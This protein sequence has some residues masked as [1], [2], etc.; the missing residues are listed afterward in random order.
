L[1]KI[2]KKADQRAIKLIEIGP[3]MEL[4]LVKIQSGLCDGE[5]LFHEFNKKTP[6]EI[7]KTERKRQQ[8]KQETA[9]RRKEQEKNVERKKIEKEAHRLATSGD[10]ISESEDDE[11]DEDNED[12]ES[13]AD[14]MDVDHL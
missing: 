7:K 1:S 3:R 5:I 10:V 2:N 11:G 13:S 8:K 9:L 12:E 6:A 14:E 4:Q